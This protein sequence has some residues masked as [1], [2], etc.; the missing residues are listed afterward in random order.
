MTIGR[1]KRR[2]RFCA[3][4][5]SSSIAS[6]TELHAIAACTVTPYDVVVLDL[7]LPDIDGVEVCRRLHALPMPPRI[8]M[9]TAR[10]S[11]EARVARLGERGRRLH[12][13][14]LRAVGARGASPSADAAAGR[15]RSPAAAHRH[16]DARSRD[17]ARG[18]RFARDRAH[19]ERVRRAR[20][21]DAECRASP[22]ARADQRARVGRE[23][24]SAEQR[25][26]RLHVAVAA[27][28]RRRGRPATHRDGARR[29]AIGLAGARN[30]D[31]G[32]FVDSFAAHA[33]VRVLDPS[34]V[35]RRR[36]RAARRRASYAVLG[37]RQ[38][39][40]RLVDAGAPVLPRRGD[41]I[42]R[43]SNRP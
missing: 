34:A 12:R 35:R 22:D 41:R 13:K 14:T 8:L 38:R 21:S 15:G 33:L 42:S 28:D 30:R 18:A 19:D 4:P 26:R 11:V 40:V 32:A 27:K 3:R 23:L 20:V 37:V 17:A 29:R 36:L 43:R 6:A 31:D 39:R 16:A 24:R 2:V 25:R 9:A 5:V 10:D 7:G 1:P